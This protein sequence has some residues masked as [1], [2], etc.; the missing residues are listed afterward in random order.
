MNDPKETIVLFVFIAVFITAVFFLC[1]G[2]TSIHDIRKRA[3]PLRTE[4][5]NARRTQQEQA[6]TL[7]EAGK[8]VTRSR[9][10][11]K[12]SERT[13]KEIAGIEQ[14][15]AEIIA[16]C[17]SIVKNVRKR[18]RTQDQSKDKTKKSMDSGIHR[19]GDIGREITFE[20]AG[21]KIK[22]ADKY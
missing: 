5:D 3:E 16:E 1:S 17:Q 9:E 18:S 10:A 12:D 13:N 8:A 2:R 19:T 4:L 15:D 22:R 21:R 11:V 7:N 14:G 20:K 6:N